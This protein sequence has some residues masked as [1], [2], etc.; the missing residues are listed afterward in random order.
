MSPLCP[1]GEG[2]TNLPPLTYSQHDYQLEPLSSLH[3]FHSLWLLAGD[4]AHTET[5]DTAA[6]L[7]T[8]NFPML[9]MPHDQCNQRGVTGV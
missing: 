4:L 2:A 9:L 5:P 7:Q 3:G 1:L 6:A 8:L